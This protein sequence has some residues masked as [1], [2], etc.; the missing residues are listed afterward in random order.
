MRSSGPWLQ[1]WWTT[2]FLIWERWRCDTISDFFNGIALFTFL[3]V[4][5]FLCFALLSTL[6]SFLSLSL[7][8]FS[9]VLISVWLISF[10]IHQFLIFP[11]LSFAFSPHSYLIIH[12]NLFVWFCVYF[13]SIAYL[14]SH[15]FTGFIFSVQLT[16]FSS[17]SVKNTR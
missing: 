2:G 13:F 9:P 3:F 8:C 17:V 11:V 12:V 16:S 10:S 1:S 4:F 14:L 15:V 7:F 5:I 6:Y